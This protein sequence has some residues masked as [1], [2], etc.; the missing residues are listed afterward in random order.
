MIGWN[1]SY[2]WT[3]EEF[4]KVVITALEID[5][6]ES[7][8]LDC[9]HASYDNMKQIVSWAEERGYHAEMSDSRETVRVWKS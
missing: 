4:K 3:Y 2:N 7:V 5:D 6:K 1:E 8:N 9:E